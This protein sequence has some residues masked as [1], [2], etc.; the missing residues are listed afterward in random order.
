VRNAEGGKYDA[1]GVNVIILTTFCQTIRR[2][3]CLMA[4]RRGSGRENMT[5]TSQA[6]PAACP[7]RDTIAALGR[8]KSEQRPAEYGE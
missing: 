6:M 5:C 8:I 3:R 4:G 1:N 2:I 7:S